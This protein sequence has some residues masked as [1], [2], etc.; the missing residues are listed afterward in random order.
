MHTEFSRRC[1]EHQREAL[2]TSSGGNGMKI[3]VFYRALRNTNQDQQIKQSMQ[4]RLT[5]IA[6]HGL[7][8]LSVELE[9]I[10]KCTFKT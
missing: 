8:F 4:I 9:Q 6:L 3:D 10:F 7:A 2:E 5:V 1:S